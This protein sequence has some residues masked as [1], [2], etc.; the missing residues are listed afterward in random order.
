MCVDGSH[1]SPTAGF[2]VGFLGQE[3][4]FIFFCKTMFVENVSCSS[5]LNQKSVSTQISAYCPCPGSHWLYL[6]REHV[7]LWK[8][9]EESGNMIVK[10]PVAANGPYSYALNWKT[11]SMWTSFC[12]FPEN[13]GM[14]TVVG[15]LWWMMSL[16]KIGNIGYK[17]PVEV[18]ALCFFASKK[19]VRV[20]SWVYFW[21]HSCPDQL[22]SWFCQKCENNCPP[23]LTRRQSSPRRSRLEL[24]AAHLR[25]LGKNCIRRPQR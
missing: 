25:Q 18:D 17:F 11:F 2:V 13:H 1:Q 9:V 6:H 22:E 4:F 16:D 19:K 14:A 10:T 3:S 12:L 23:Q 7:P 15:P 8:R 21:L 5:A 24:S 20:P